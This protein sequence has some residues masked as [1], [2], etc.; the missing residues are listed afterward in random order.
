MSERDRATAASSEEPVYAGRKTPGSVRAALLTLQRTIA[1][2]VLAVVG[3]SVVQGIVFFRIVFPIAESRESF[4]GMGVGGD[5]LSALL[6]QIGMIVVLPLLLWLVAWVLEEK[7]LVLALGAGLMAEG[8]YLI[9][10]LFTGGQEY[11]AAK[12]VYFL[13]RLVILSVT[14]VLGALAYRHARRLSEHRG[15]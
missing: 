8:W 5:V 14:V 6:A 2:G 4:Y 11:F 12:P 15:R 9:L 7:P 1:I 13:S 10:A 3:A